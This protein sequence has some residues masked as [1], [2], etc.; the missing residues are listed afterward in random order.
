MQDPL[1]DFW[2]LKSCFFDKR[3]LWAPV[4]LLKGTPY[5]HVQYYCF[6]FFILVN[7]RLGLLSPHHEASIEEISKVAYIEALKIQIYKQ[8]SEVFHILYIV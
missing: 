4:Q 5:N 3:P 6:S 7:W 1:R 2:N 8:W